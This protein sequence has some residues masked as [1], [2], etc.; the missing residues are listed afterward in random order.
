MQ[1]PEYS[2]GQRATGESF[3]GMI[4]GRPGGGDGYDPSHGGYGK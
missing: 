2:Q 3:D 4:A 1:G